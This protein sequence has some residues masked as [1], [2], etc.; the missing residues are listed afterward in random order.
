[1][2]SED[3]ANK[4][5][6][7]FKLDE[8]GEVSSRITTHQYMY[9]VDTFIEEALFAMMM[10]YEGKFNAILAKELLMEHFGLEE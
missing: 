4:V 8:T 9:L 1:M 5:G 3:I 2:L 6:L 10:S 7:D